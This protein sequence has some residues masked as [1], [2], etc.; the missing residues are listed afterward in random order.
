MDGYEAASRIRDICG[1]ES[2]IPIIF[3]SALGEDA[4]L[5]RGIAAGGDDYLGKPVSRV[6]LEA[7]LRAME[8]IAGM[9]KTVADYAASIELMHK[10]QSEELETAREVFEKMTRIE[11]IP[12]EFVRVKTRPS[13]RFSG[14]VV[15]AGRT[16]SGRL[17]VLLADATGH[18][19]AAGLTVIPLT[20][21]YYGTIAQ[22]VSLGVLVQRLNAR[23]CGLL[24]VGRFV[25]AILVA[26]EPMLRRVRVW[27]GGC[28]N[29]LCVDAE[30]RIVQ[31]FPSVS[32]PLGV[33]P[34]SRPPELVTFDYD[35]RSGQKMYLYSDGL[36]EAEDP[37]G[38]P[39]T[40]RRIEQILASAAPR[41]RTQTLFDALDEHCAGRALAD[42]VTFVELTLEHQPVH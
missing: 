38:K 1:A 10:T 28:P 9:R 7:K 2:W 23:L 24:P 20:D 37:S 8:R 5:A 39:F 18:G 12:A 3:L 26:V 31:V 42:D 19:L 33:V 17:S 13:T 36:P 34:F 41:A 14:D 4:D 40:S 21:L 16:P 35:S 6:V 11:Q 25:A 27:N 22:D 29:A 32:A 30:G 15:A